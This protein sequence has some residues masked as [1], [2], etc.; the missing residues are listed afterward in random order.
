MNAA[1]LAIQRPAGA[2]LLVA[3]RR[4]HVEHWRR[5]AFVQ[6]LQRGDLIVANDAATLP[7]SLVGRHLASGR[8]VEAR[9]AAS[10][11]LAVDRAVTFTAVLFGLGDFRMRTEDRPDPPA[12]CPG[13]RLAL[14]P[15]HATVTHLVR[16][17]PRLVGLDFNGTAGEIWEGLGRY[18]RPIQY[19]HLP[20]PLAMWD[21]WTPIAGLP[22]A[23]EPPSAG[24]MLDWAAVAS[25]AARG[26][27]FA[28]LT[29]AAGLSSTGDPQL[30]AL[31]PFEEPYR[32]PA[33]TAAAIAA[34]RACGGRIVAVGTS[35]VRALE[36]AAT[37]GGMVRTGSGVA[38]NRIGALTPLRVV[39]AVF[40]GVHEPGTSHYELLRAFVDDPTLAYMNGALRAQD[41]CTHEFGDSIFIERDLKR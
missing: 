1:P 7:A 33:S 19:S 20:T 5:S 24:F 25:L 39:D 15:L 6:L 23:F 40:S 3:D 16:N 35:V 13:D 21:T 2:K 38:T 36:H 27:N 10:P 11:A 37:E 29:H 17:H 18:G 32:I 14:G 9:L 12:V 4:G 31:L 34:A 22:V 30:D 8:R 26:A 28:T 41:Y